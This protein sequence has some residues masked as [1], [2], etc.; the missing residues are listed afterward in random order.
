MCRKICC[1]VLVTV[2]TLGLTAVNSQNAIALVIHS[3]RHKGWEQKNNI[4]SGEELRAKKEIGR[5]MHQLGYSPAEVKA[6]LERL[7]GKQLCHLADNLCLIQ[8]GSGSGQETYNSGELA[9]GILFVVILVGV[10]AASG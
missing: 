3:Q 4:A 8:Q 7:S 1:V 10:W 2:L 6:R 5:R 9:L